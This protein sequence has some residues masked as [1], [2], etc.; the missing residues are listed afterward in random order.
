MG[1]AFVSPLLPN[2]QLPVG[3]GILVPLFELVSNPTIR[4]GDVKSRRF[5]MWPKGCLPVYKKKRVC[6]S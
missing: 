5:F 4:I 2:Q 1:N 6:E 3:K